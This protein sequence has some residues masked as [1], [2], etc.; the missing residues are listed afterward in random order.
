M[1]RPTPDV[2]CAIDPGA[3]KLVAVVIFVK[4]GDP[5]DNVYTRLKPKLKSGDPSP[6][7]RMYICVC[8]MCTS[9]C[10]VLDIITKS[11]PPLDFNSRA[12]KSV[13]FGDLRGNIFHFFVRL[14]LYVCVYV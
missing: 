9:T 13:S 8:V 6:L 11:V 3:V 12:Q 14:I 1:S 4:K 5:A 10:H 2:V 7:V